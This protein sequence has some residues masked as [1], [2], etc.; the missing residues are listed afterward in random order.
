MIIPEEKV[1]LLKEALNQPWPVAGIELFSSTKS[2]NRID[3]S[4]IL[5][6]LLQ[7][8]FNNQRIALHLP[9]LP[10]LHQLDTSLSLSHKILN[11][12]AFV[13][14]YYQQLDQHTYLDSEVL[15]LLYQ[16]R[17]TLL[18]CILY[19]DNILTNPR[20][21]LRIVIEDICQWGIGWDKNI[22]KVGEKFF[23]SLNDLVTIGNNLPEDCYVLP[24][25]YSTTLNILG[26]LTARYQQLGLR[27]FK[28]EQATMDNLAIRRQVEAVIDEYVEG[29]PM[30]AAAITFFHGVWRDILHR[31]HVLNNA[32]GA[33]WKEFLQLMDQLIF[34]LSPQ[35]NCKQE[36]INLI[37]GIIQALKQLLQK[38]GFNNSH[39]Y[40]FDDIIGIFK[41]LMTGEKI[42][43]Q[44]APSLSRLNIGGVTTTISSSIAQQ[45]IRLAPDQWVLCKGS[46]DE[47]VRCR[48]VRIFPDARQVLLVNL[49]G[50]KPMTKSVEEFGLAINTKRAHLLVAKNL[51]NIV[52]SL[53]IDFFI[54]DYRKAVP[55]T[56]PSP[57][58]NF[59]KQSAEKALIEAQKLREAAKAKPVVISLP[60]PESQCNRIEAMV[61]ELKIGSWLSMKNRM[62][63]QIP[64]KI[65]VIYGSTGKMVMTDKIGLRVGEYLQPELVALIMKGEASIIKIAD[66]FEEALSRVVQ[67][68]RKNP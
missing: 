46:N 62:G 8:A 7:D 47:M 36:Q 23:N 65:A 60:L 39:A 61:N 19:S 49:L 55:D 22:G 17:P 42:P 52:L 31:Q 21:P 25:S 10:Q 18:R 63:E 33:E 35:P 5:W 4:K 24:D 32:N 30:P 67:T 34:C 64:C 37:P 53:T 45:V 66:S 28:N 68:L 11:R 16:L 40:L 43:M 38:S 26:D 2:A 41:Q 27:I 15:Q 58:D 50:A 9:V 54:R 57:I 44:L 3:S 1:T 56:V 59:R 14:S 6:L 20:H 13:D 12:L 48:L 51:S 29:K